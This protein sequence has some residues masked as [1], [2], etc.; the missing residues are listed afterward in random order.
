MRTD[1][2]NNAPVNGRLHAGGGDDDVGAKGLTRCQRG[3]QRPLA[4]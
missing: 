2:H 4:G 3:Q 1:T